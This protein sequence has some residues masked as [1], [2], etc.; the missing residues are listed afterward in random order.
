MLQ[1]SYDAA[2]L[3]LVHFNQRRVADVTDST[4]D[5][6]GLTLDVAGVFCEHASRAL[7]QVLSPATWQ[8]AQHLANGRHVFRTSR[9]ALERQ[10][11]RAHPG[12]TNVSNDFRAS[13]PNL[14]R[15]ASAVYRA[16]SSVGPSSRRPKGAP[17][18][19]ST[20]GASLVTR[21]SLSVGYDIFFWATAHPGGA[22]AL[23]SGNLDNHSELSCQQ[24]RRRNCAPAGDSQSA[25][26]RQQPTTL[27]I[28]RNS[29]FWSQWT[30]TRTEW[31]GSDR[32]TPPVRKSIHNNE[33]GAM[34]A[35]HRD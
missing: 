7:C 35:M 26:S 17:G 33:M 12:T 2:V 13:G 24:R 6:H 16:T 20:T 32:T 18:W 30:V 11:L 23:Q 21:E 10:D 14:E 28:H 1:G 27:A 5:D 34:G 22:K 19:Y 3:S 8:P 4:D 29:L 25:I 9:P 15:H 31:H